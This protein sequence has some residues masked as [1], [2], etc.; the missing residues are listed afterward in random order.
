MTYKNIFSIIVIIILIILSF[1]LNS[2]YWAISLIGTLL[3]Y[4][5]IAFLIYVWW[6]KLRKKDYIDYREFAIW[7]LYKISLFTLILS[8]ILWS[9]AYFENEI[10]PAPMPRYVIS[11]GDKEVVF[12][13]MSHIWSKEFYNTIRKDLIDYKSASGVY[14]YEWVRPWSEKNKKDFNKA[15]WIKFD[16]WLYKKFSKLYGVEYQDNTI[17]YNL[18]N[19]LDFNVDLSIDDIMNLY[20]KDPQKTKSLTPPIDATK[21]ITDTL[22]SLNDREL[23]ILVYVNQAILNFII[24]SDWL[25][26]VITTNFA[27]K[28][29]FDVILWERNKVVSNTIIKSKYKKIYITYWLLHFKGVLEL[30][31]QNDSKWKIIDI[32]RLYPIK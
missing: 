25:K 31:K 18:V 1:Y 16:K 27:N 26:D 14:F 17:Y 19:N 8:T 9:F 3:I 11:N 4:Y 21:T 13:A 10:S 24:K 28:K 20:N 30:L 6:K 5:I 12:Q 22:T 7:F 29:L 23:Q 32:R 15:I 2:F